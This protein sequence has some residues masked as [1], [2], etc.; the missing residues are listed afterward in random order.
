MLQGVQKWIL[1]QHGRRDDRSKFEETLNAM[2]VKNRALEQQV[3][4][5]KLKASVRAVLAP[6]SPPSSPPSPSPP[7]PSPQPPQPPPLSAAEKKKRV[8]E[9]NN[10]AVQKHK[11]R[12]G[13]NARS[14]RA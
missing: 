13:V 4:A 2:T 11:K 5:L 1:C 6:P 3:S 8:D 9:R 7:S 10:A 12:N 14:G